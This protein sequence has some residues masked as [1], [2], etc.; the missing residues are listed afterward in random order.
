ML[1]LVGAAVGQLSRRVLAP[2]PPP[3]PSATALANLVS[4]MLVGQWATLT[5]INMA[6]TLVE[7]LGGTTDPATGHILG[8]IDKGCWD[9]IAKRIL[10]VTSDHFHGSGGQARFPQWDDATNTWSRLTPGSWF[11]IVSS[12]ARHGYHHNSIDVAGRKLYHKLFSVREV[13]RLDLSQPITST[14]T[15]LTDPPT[16][17]N[18][19]A[20]GT[21]FVP[22]VGS[23]GSLMTHQTDNGQN[24]S[25]Y[26]WDV[27]SNAWTIPANQTIP[28]SGDIHC[29]FEAAPS[30]QYAVMGGGSNDAGS[31][32]RNV[33]V[34]Q[35]NGTLLISRTTAPQSYQIQGAIVTHCPVSGDFI[36]IWGVNNWW[37]YV[38]PTNTWTQMPGTCHIFDGGMQDGVSSPIACVA[39]P[40]D[41]YGVIVFAKMVNSTPT[42]WVY[43]HA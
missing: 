6:S 7:P 27:N 35:P 30:I 10:F 37:K 22:W 9:S 21:D 39:I 29:I 43:R 4:N 41:T 26:R 34:L 11:P 20:I 2:P 3:P 8:Y 14:W 32:G 24:G 17:Y 38:A 19:S 18:A 13:Y 42:F 1:N 15:R 23:Q 28:D 12:S 33:S 36:F 31:D 40:V 16:N 25:M 5:T